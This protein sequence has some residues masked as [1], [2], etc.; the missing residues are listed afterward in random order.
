MPRIPYGTKYTAQM[1]GAI[2]K[3][4]V[5]ENCG[6][7]YFYLAKAKAEGSGE[8]ILWLN[9]HAAMAKAENTAAEKLEKQL[10]EIVLNYHCPECGFYQAHMLQRMKNQIWKNTF[11][12]GFFSAAIAFVIVSGN[13]IPS[14]FSTLAAGVL[15]SSFFWCRLINFDPNA[16]AARRGKKKFSNQYPVTQKS[17]LDFLPLVVPK[18]LADITNDSEGKGENPNTQWIGVVLPIVSVIALFLYIQSFSGSAVPMVEPTRYIPPTLQ[19]VP[20]NTKNTCLLWSQV[21]PAMAGQTRCVYGTVSRVYKNYQ[22]G[23]SFIYFGTEDQFFF[24][25]EFVWKDIKGKCVQ[26]TGT[27]GI[28]TYHVP[29]IL[30]GP[31]LDSCQ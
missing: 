2:W 29:Y 26:T 16:D 18:N 6:C 30:T 23:Q 31:T 21:T 25:N 14:V 13:S 3:P 22:A 7:Q 27:I 20:T 9:K 10:K 19:P 15:I 1:T 5:C 28:N 11:I 24:T 17:V 12:L 8:N 4:V